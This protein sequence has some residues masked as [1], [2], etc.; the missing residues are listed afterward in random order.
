[1][2]GFFFFLSRGSSPFTAKRL[3]AVEAGSPKQN[4]VCGGNISTSIRPCSD[5]IARKK[6]QKYNKL[7]FLFWGVEVENFHVEFKEIKML[8]RQI[9]QTYLDVV[10][11]ASTSSIT[12]KD[13]PEYKILK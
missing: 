8:L 9:F 1:M 3:G 4:E 13:R 5:E 2:E 11:P 6:E 7:F 10:V 12:D